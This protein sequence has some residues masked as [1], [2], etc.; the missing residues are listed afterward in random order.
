MASQHAM[1]ILGYLDAHVN[2]GKLE[3]RSKKGTF[4]G[5]PDGVK[6]YK[7]WLTSPNG[8]KTVISRHVFLLE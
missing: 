8:G 1:I 4:L 3:P 7:V 2:E 6:G 5:Y